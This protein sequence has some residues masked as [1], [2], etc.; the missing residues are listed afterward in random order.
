MYYLKED[1]SLDGPGA[2]PIPEELIP[3]CDLD[4]TELP[5]SDVNEKKDALWFDA[6]YYLFNY[7]PQCSAFPS[8]MT[9]Y[10]ACPDSSAK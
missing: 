1:R 4:D 2:I 10:Y 9:T 7:F 5:Q 8:N 6:K 3:P